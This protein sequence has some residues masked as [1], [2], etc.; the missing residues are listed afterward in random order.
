MHNKSQLRVHP[1]S[2][3]LKMNAPRERRG[4]TSIEKE[5]L[6]GMEEMFERNSLPKILQ[7][8]N[9]LLLFLRDRALPFMACI[10]IYDGAGSLFFILFITRFIAGL[11]RDV[12]L[13]YVVVIVCDTIV[14]LFACVSRKRRGQ[15]GS[16]RGT[17]RR[18][19]DEQDLCPRA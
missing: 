18:E 1:R 10:V 8:R 12:E 4:R 7:T 15:N 3:R 6:G 5:F 19:T 17:R 9:E 13:F 2:P 14:N 16:L 11:F